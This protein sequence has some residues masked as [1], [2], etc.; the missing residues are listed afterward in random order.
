MIT[1]RRGS[2]Y[3]PVRSE[4]QGERS[5]VR[6]AK[7]Q[8]P[9]GCRETS[10]TRFLSE[11][12]ETHLTVRDGKLFLEIEFRLLY[13][14]KPLSLDPLDKRGQTLQMGDSWLVTSGLDIPGQRGSLG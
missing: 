10:K 6:E 11:H 5:K 3:Q 7:N 8:S 2:R 1:E 14:R 12:E 9:F 4:W 13:S